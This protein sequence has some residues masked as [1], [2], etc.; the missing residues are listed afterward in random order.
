MSKIED[1]YYRKTRQVEDRFVL[2]FLQKEYGET[3]C[4]ILEVGSGLGRFA[5]KLKEQTSSRICCIEK[6][7]DLGKV[8]QACDIRTI[9][10]DLTDIKFEDESFDVIHCSHVIEHLPYPQIADTLDIFFKILKPNGYIIIRSPLLSDKFYFD[11][12]HI[13]PYPP[14]SILSYFSNSEQQRKSKNKI[15]VEKIRYRRQARIPFPY[16]I[17]GFR[18]MINRTMMFLWTVIRFPQSLPNGY[19]LILKKWNTE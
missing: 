14:Q 17:N 11:L 15:K 7:P 5:M 9:V 1:K 10:G 16:A 8:T 2:D 13:R 4:D 12:D 18:L 19:T 6:N 3:V